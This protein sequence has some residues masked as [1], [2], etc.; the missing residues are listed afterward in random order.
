MGG[1]ISA[2][3]ISAIM[4]GC[5]ADPAKALAWEPV[6]FNPAQA[7]MMA[8]I[9]E[10]IMPTTDTHGAKEAG[11]APFIDVVLKDCYRGK[12]Q[13]A[14]LAGLEK[15]EQDSQNDYGT[16]FINLDAEKMDT[17]LT[18]Y[19][20]AA[21][22]Q[23]QNP[24]SKERHFFSTLKELTILGYFTSEIGATETLHYESVPGAYV[25]CKPLAEVGKTWAR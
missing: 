7:L 23:R 20:K 21:Y 10:R 25:G 6:F 19:D 4:S 9:A 15:I 1:V 11:V 24:A 12:G 16:S 18:K 2:S 17:L 3:A 5:Q 14:V 22:E 8:E 13:K